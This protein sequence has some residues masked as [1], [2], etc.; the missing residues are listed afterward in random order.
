MYKGG[1]RRLAT[2]AMDLDIPED[3]TG[4]ALTASATTSAY[5][6]RGPNGAD[7]KGVHCSCFDD[8]C[9][10]CS[11]D[12]AIPSRRITIIISRKIY[13]NYKAATRWCRKG[14]APSEVVRYL[15]YSRGVPSAALSSMA[16]SGVWV[17]YS[18]AWRHV[19]P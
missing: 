18:S 11:C 9:F 7:S 1:G 5:K 2:H 17:P 14:R 16:S 13:D 3:E 8:F 4:I 12:D 6:T 15:R 19:A 10:F